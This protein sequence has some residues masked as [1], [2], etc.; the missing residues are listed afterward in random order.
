MEEFDLD[1]EEGG[2]AFD[3]ASNAPM[4]SN[5]G[6]NDPNSVTGS[7]FFKTI[8]GLTNAAAGVIRASKGNSKTEKNRSALKLSPVLIIGIGIAVVVVFAL[9]FRKK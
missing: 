6:R 7:G 2:N 5:T 1:S 3:N 4:V 9:L 8:E